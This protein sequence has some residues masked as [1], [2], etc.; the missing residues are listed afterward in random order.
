MFTVA[1][2]SLHAVTPRC[3]LSGFLSGQVPMFGKN[4]L[5]AH[6]GLSLLTPNRDLCDCLPHNLP[7]SSTLV[8]DGA[9]YVHHALLYCTTRQ[10]PYLNTPIMHFLHI[11]QYQ[12]QFPH[13]CKN[14]ILP[15]FSGCAV[16]SSCSRFSTAG[17]ISLSD[18]RL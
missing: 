4:L 5:P 7:T 1:T 13:I 10:R 16:T 9:Y 12:A 18:G 2:G 15:N 8:G 6:L 11:I 14:Q 17:K 3:K